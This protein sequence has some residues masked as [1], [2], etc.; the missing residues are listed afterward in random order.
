M[1]PSPPAILEPAFTITASGSY[2]MPNK[3]AAPSP[4]ARVVKPKARIV[5]SVTSLIY[6]SSV[7][8]LNLSE[9]HPAIGVILAI[10]S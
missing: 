2:I 4:P 9:A 5:S 7:K 1:S 3:L 6:S 8:L 10:K